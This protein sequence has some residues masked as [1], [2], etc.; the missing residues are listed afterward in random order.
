VRVGIDLDGVCYDFALHLRRYL[1][2][3]L[4]HAP[5]PYEHLHSWDFWTRWGWD[6]EH[7]YAACR[8]A[9]DAGCLFATG[10]PHRGTQEALTALAAAGHELHGIPYTSLTIS[11][12]KTSVPT[13]IFVED[14]LP[15]YE[16]LRAAGTTAYLINREW[17]A[18]YDD[19]RNRVA[20]IGEFARV[21]LGTA[22]Q[23]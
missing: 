11:H 7:Y 13:D 20:D 12:D 5:E 3:W 8:E 23:G 2:E 14:Y 19:G 1:V 9:V 16:K 18:P 10:E 17:N 21:V 22:E 15:N 6:D 4:G